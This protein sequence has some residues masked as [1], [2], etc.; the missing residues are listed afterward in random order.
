[1]R[2]YD[3]DFGQIL[4]DGVDIQNYSIKSL[5]ESMGLVM[6]EPTLFNYTIRE[7]ILYGNGKATNQ[8]II[9]AADIA[10]ARGF[11]ESDD[12][13]DALDDNPL[14]LLEAAKKENYKKMLIEF[15]GGKE[16]YDKKIVD[17]EGL[18]KAQ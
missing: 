17:L 14:T 9:D 8:S 1:M 3:P 18:V 12:I 2:F 4:I 13:Q 15:F 7:N 10:S 11:I 5:R 6:Q 16:A